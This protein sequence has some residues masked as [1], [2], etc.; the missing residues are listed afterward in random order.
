MGRLV[1]ALVSAVFLMGPALS[2]TV[3]AQTDS[4]GTG[5]ATSGDTTGSTADAN[6]TTTLD[7]RISERKAAAKLQLTAARQA[8]LK[9]KCKAAQGLVK[10]AN[11]RADKMVQNRDKVYSDLD[12]RIT[13]ITTRLENQKADVTALKDLKANLHTATGTFNADATKYQQALKDAGD[14]DCASDPAGFVASLQ[15]A[16]DLRLKLAADSKA[17]RDLIPQIGKALADVNK[18]LSG[19][20]H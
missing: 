19:G 4:T 9:T 18:S 6:S 1:V 8:A 17:I 7:Q 13:L 3:F 2:A 10:T 16:R 15:T 14:M 20:T 11:T 5:T 12:T